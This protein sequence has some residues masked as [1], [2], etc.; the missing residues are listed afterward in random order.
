MSSPLEGFE[1]SPQQRRLWRRERIDGAHLSWCELSV[2]G[3]GAVAALVAALERVTAR[4]EAYRIALRTVAG[5]K[6]PLQV[7]TGHGGV[8]LREARASFGEVLAA[9]RTNASDLRD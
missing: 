1:L 4:H 3:S 6:L 7:F 9:L 8:E 5:L 2:A